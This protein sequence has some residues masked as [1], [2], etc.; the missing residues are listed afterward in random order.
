LVISFLFGKLFKGESKQVNKTREAFV[1]A[2]GG[3]DMLNQHAARA[4]VTLDEFLKVSKV[5]DYEREVAELEAAFAALD[6]RIADTVT[7]ID[8]V[9]GA[10]GIISGDLWSKIIQDKD[11]EDIKA[12]LLEVFDTSVNQSAEGFNKIAANFELIK[13]PLGQIGVLADA[14]FGGLLANGVSVIAAIQQLGP[15]LQHIQEVLAKTGQT[16]TGPLAD[17]LNYQKIVE[18]NA[19]I[20]E[21]LSGVDDMLVGLANSGLLTQTSFSALGATITQAFTQLTANGVAGSTAMQLMQPQLQKLWELQKQFGFS[22]DSSTQSLLNQAEQQGIVGAQMQSTEQKILDV[23]IAIGTALGATIPD[24]LLGL[25][26]VAQEAAAGI[27]EAFAPEKIT[28]KFQAIADAAISALDQIPNQVPIDLRLK[29]RGEEQ[30][31]KW[32]RAGT[33]G[34]EASIPHFAEGG[35]VTRPTLGLIGEAGPEAVVPLDD[36]QSNRGG[37]HIEK[38]YGTVDRA[39]VKNVARV[40][41]QGGDVK[42]AMQG[43]LR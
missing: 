2:A 15:G 32:F 29:L 10:G 22:V 13:A 19:G 39:F 43:A 6:Q 9:L 21:L 17:L 42:T 20:F 31:Q 26:P 23:L 34:G 40:I 5:K 4:G 8:K 7:E 16:P 18:A 14:A 41:S 33:P 25:P 36:F 24:A 12:K 27:G 1:Q 30:F 35:I 11:A 28:P 38:V 3:L 37:V